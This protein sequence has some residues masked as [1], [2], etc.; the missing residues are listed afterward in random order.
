MAKA[1]ASPA[2]QAKNAVQQFYSFEQQG[3]F[4]SSWM[5]FHPS[6]KEIFKKGP[7]IHRSPCT[8]IY[9]SF[10]RRDLHIYTQQTKEDKKL[11][12]VQRN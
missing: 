6:L 12:N 8:R 2:Q 1:F 5:L 7:Y 3:E 9:E 4:A 10:W 11:E